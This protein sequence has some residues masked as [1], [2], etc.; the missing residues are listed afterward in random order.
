M[1]VMKVKVSDVHEETESKEVHTQ[2]ASEARTEP[3]ALEGL[4][5]PPTLM[6]GLLT[7]GRYLTIQGWLRTS[8]NDMRFEG[9]WMRSYHK[10]NQD[11]PNLNGQ[12]LT[13]PIKSFASEE[14]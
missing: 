8:S 5:E 6:L 7:L 2:T 11:T 14:K 4:T 13:F 9:E 10:I 1:R 3:K 12:V